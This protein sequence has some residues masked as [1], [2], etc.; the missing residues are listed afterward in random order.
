MNS[1]YWKTKTYILPQTFL[2]KQTQK[3]FQSIKMTN[4]SYKS[5][6]IFVNRYSSYVTCIVGHVNVSFIR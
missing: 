6:F 3:P 4:E 1:T 2:Q 5:N